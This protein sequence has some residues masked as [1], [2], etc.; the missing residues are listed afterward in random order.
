MKRP[1][2]RTDWPCIKRRH[3]NFGLEE[4][5]REWAFF[6]SLFAYEQLR[7]LYALHGLGQWL[8]YDIVRLILV[9]FMY[10]SCLERQC[11][12]IIMPLTERTYVDEE[13]PVLFAEMRTLVRRFQGDKIEAERKAL[14]DKGTPLERIR[15]IC[16]NDN[17]RDGLGAMYEWRD[18][19]LDA[20]DPCDGWLVLPLPHVM[21]C[22]DCEDTETV[23]LY[24]G[25]YGGETYHEVYEG[26]DAYIDDDSLEVYDASLDDKS[27]EIYCNDG[28]PPGGYELYEDV[29]EE[30]FPM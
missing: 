29:D 2:D 15:I 30:F 13:T 18:D 28:E 5:D 26:D 21:V 9:D 1:F 19:Y 4:Q 6:E 16:A 10:V 23:A 20:I 12:R 17:P 27:P 25:F 14:L 3:L 8:D 11:N 7:W 24:V 22:V